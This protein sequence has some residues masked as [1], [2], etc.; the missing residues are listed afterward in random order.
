MMQSSSKRQALAR[1]AVSYWLG[2]V[3]GLIGLLASLW[4]FW[5]HSAALHTSPL[6]LPAL[7]LKPPPLPEQAIIVPS[8]PD[9]IQAFQQITVE[10]SLF[11]SAKRAGLSD[12]LIMDLAH[13]F[14]WDIDFAQ[15]IKP[16][17]SF[18]ILYE[19]KYVEGVKVGTGNILAA[20][21]KGQQKQHSAIRF[22]TRD[23]QTD[24]YTANGV[25]VRKAFIRTPVKF[26]RVSS[27]FNLHREHPVLHK[28]RAHKGV[29]YAAPRGTPV[30]AAGDGVLHFIGRQGGYGKV[31]EIQH[32]QRY[33]TLYAHL[34]N[35]APKLREGMRVKQ[36][37][38]IGT[39]GSTGLA[40]GPHLHYEFRIDGVH[41]NPITVALPQ[42][43]PITAQ[44]R[45]RFFA[46]A[47]L[48]LNHMARQKTIM[49]ASTP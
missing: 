46:H 13:I 44:D 40:T 43:S 31:I 42:S 12:K 15:D 39:V 11:A 38:V 9:M 20:T 45:H 6:S 48:L 22:T 4:F 19:E 3:G 2:A 29:D 5:P 21:F 30:K 16:H 27:P 36:G 34:A 17:D 7:A 8:K 28:I 10:G 18:Q 35:F 33:S 49:L 41:H 24:Y 25:P 23:G 32:G 47:E 1:F 14:A 26:S 37:Q